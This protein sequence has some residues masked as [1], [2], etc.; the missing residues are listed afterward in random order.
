MNTKELRE[1][2][3]TE[4]ETLKLDILRENFNLRMQRGSG[5]LNQ[6]HL[7]RDSRRNVARIETILTEKKQEKTGS[8][9]GES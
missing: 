7:L 1:K 9:G 8:A 3:V 6:K 4:L 2:S 5:Q